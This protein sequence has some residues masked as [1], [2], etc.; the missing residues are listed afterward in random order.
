MNTPVFTARHITAFLTSALDSDLTLHFG[1][2]ISK[3]TDHK[4][5]GNTKQQHPGTKEATQKGYFCAVQKLIGDH[6]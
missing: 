6:A 2:I 5:H 1:A 3:E 4:K